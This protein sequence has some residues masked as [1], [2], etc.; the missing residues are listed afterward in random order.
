MK[1]EVTKIPNL[2]TNGFIK[3]I[4][5]DGT[6]DI[7]LNSYA[8]SSSIGNGILTLNTGTYLSGSTTFSANQTG[9]TT[10]NVTTNAT[11]ANTASTIVARDSNGNF[12]AGAISATTFTGTLIGSA[13]NVANAI[14]FNTTGGESGG[15]T[16]NGSI[17]R[18][19]DYSTIGAAPLSG[20]TYYVPYTG[21]NGN[22]NL[23]T[24]N[25]T[26]NGKVGIGTSVPASLLHTAGTLSGSTGI[27]YSIYLNPNI[28]Q[29]GTAGYTALYINATHTTTGSGNQNLISAA[30]GGVE[31]FAVGSDGAIASA[32]GIKNNSSIT[33]ASIGTTTSGV[34]ISRNIA[35]ANAALVVSNSNSGSTGNILTLNNS[36][37]SK[38]VVTSGGTVGIG[39]ATPLQTGSLTIQGKGTGT[40]AFITMQDSNADCWWEIANS[41]RAV[42]GGYEIWQGV[43]GIGSY[44]STPIDILLNDA[45]IARWTTNGYLILGD[46]SH[47]VPNSKLD[48]WGEISISGTTLF[49]APLKNGSTGT[50]RQKLVGTSATTSPTWAN[51]TSQLT[52]SAITTTNLD[53]NADTNFYIIMDKNII[54]TVSNLATNIGKTG[55]IVLDQNG[56]GGWSFTKATE[57]KTP[58]GGATIVQVT[59]A[60]TTS[61][62]TYY[63]LSATKI[64]INYIGNFA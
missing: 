3:T 39:T 55:S 32:S 35:D 23:G 2:L 59:T 54:F 46:N 44:T 12:L 1:I 40:N 48:V 37:G 34:I 58:L 22:V 49:T 33:Y 10:F 20:S 13:T 64:L 45:S 18:T 61:M 11:S 47:L 62:I 24:N 8:L 25:L 14:T 7:D 26:L 31:K 5:S 63:V 42:V 57:M 30:V 16:Y 51:E 43:L 9:N 52:V 38:F 28:N 6:L 41:G 21:A 60:S 36:A 50:A 53:F 19:I 27:E 17:A 29:S 56:T 15:T 4:N